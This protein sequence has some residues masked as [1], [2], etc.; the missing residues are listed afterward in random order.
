MQHDLYFLDTLRLSKK[1]LALKFKTLLLMGLGS[2]NIFPDSTNFPVLYYSQQSGHFFRQ[3]LEPLISRGP[4]HCLKWLQ[5][6]FYRWLSKTVRSVA[7]LIAF[8]AQILVC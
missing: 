7:T 6:S 8:A 2:R 4:D 5:P 1:P 3:A